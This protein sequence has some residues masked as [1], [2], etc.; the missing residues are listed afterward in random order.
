MTNTHKHCPVC[1]S[2]HL[3]HKWSVNKYSLIECKS[4]S[5]VFVKEIPSST[6]L[7]AYY[8]AESDVAYSNDNIECLNY[9]YE[10]LRDII[11]KYHPTPGRILDIGC[12]GGWFL[13]VMNNWEC[14]GTEISQADANLAKKNHR[15]NIFVGS[16]EDYPENNGKFDVITLQDVFDHLPQP[17]EALE[18]CHRLLKPN[19]LIVIKVHNISCL[20]AK[21]T[22]SNFYA[23]IPPGHL[24][25]Y[26][27]NT[28]YRILQNTGFSPVCYKYIPH[29]LK[30][31]MIF[32]RLSKGNKM[33][34]YYKIHSKLKDSVIGNIRIKKNLRDIITVFAT[35][36]SAGVH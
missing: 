29:I 7:N 23:I 32:L 9:Y 28:L 26:N 10:T 30:V 3:T 33:S 17:T 35:K 24:Y 27:K 16:F 1:N 36:T 15:D 20:Y 21:V 13:D 12:S 14:F 5:L 31:S 6:E 19:G 4:C 22:G 8:N 11:Q 34:L 18:K 25:Y 2:T